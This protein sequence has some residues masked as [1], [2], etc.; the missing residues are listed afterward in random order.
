M[1]VKIGT[2]LQ[3][4]VERVAIEMA[5]SDTYHPIADYEVVW[6]TGC[7]HVY[8]DDTLVRAFDLGEIFRK[9]MEGA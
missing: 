1:A 4:E 6:F 7:P 5:T 2:E 8:I 3:E 9:I